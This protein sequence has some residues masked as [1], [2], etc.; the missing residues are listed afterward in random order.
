MIRQA[1]KIGVSGALVALSMLATTGHS[2]AATASASASANILAPVT[3]TKTSD[4]NF[5]TIVTGTTADTVIVSAAGARTCGAALTCSGSV[6][7]AAFNV[8]G[9]A[10]TSYAITLPSTI[11]ITSGSNAMNVATFTSSKSG[12]VSTLNG[13]GAD[14]F[15]VGATLS[16]GANQAAG[17]YTGNFTVAVDYN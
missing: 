17:A 13:S 3:L 7:S 5:A 11:S 8:A 16:V 14:S 2:M 4:L 10:S 6:T 1:F 9:T 12:N 15:S